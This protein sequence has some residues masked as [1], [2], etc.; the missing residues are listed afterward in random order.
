[1]TY[2]RA[3]SLS[4]Y[5]EVAAQMGLDARA[6]LRACG[7]DRRALSDPDLRLSAASVAEL[8]EASAAAS[9]CPTFGLRMAETRRLADFG[10]ISL[11]ITHQATVRDALM[12]IIQYRRLLNESLVVTVEEDSDLVLVRE[13]LLVTRDGPMSQAYELA[14]AVMYRLFRALLGPRW[15]AMSVNFTHPS[16]PDLS[17]HRRLFGPICEF[18]S[19]FNGL[20]CSRADLDAPNPSSDPGLAQFAEQY[21]RSLPN[22]E[23]RSIAQE[24]RR[25]IYMFL[26]GG[27]AS[28]GKVAL[29]LGLSERTLQ[30]R[31][32]AA[33]LEFGALLNEVR[34]EL[35]IRYVANESFPLA[36][37]A[38]L[39]GYSQQ[40]SFS[41][42]FASEFGRSATD[43]RGAQRNR[44]LS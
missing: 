29:S 31:L 20:T 27:D 9:D 8:L 33:G 10:A 23:Q 25:A 38:G 40:S 41:R 24:T 6:M 44:A 16:P 1:M 36:R 12:T 4:N 34:R 32:A 17:V 37:V 3:A 5:A 7:I 30:R 15:R 19:D 14:I 21:V 2:V 43:W 13:E 18:G 28:I 11:L 39:V 35:A 42:W 22:S 26:A